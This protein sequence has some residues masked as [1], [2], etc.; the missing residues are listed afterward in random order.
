M[1]IIRAETAEHI[2]GIRRL[3]REYERFLGVDLCFQAF[4]EELA[5]LPGKYAPPDGAL[6]VAM[7]G[8]E[9]AGCVALRRLEQGVCEMKRLFVKEQYRGKGIG[10]ALAKGI[11]EEA[12][13]LGYSL[14]RLDTLDWLKE[15]MRLYES[16]GFRKTEPY[17]TNPLP[18]VVY[19]EL[20]I[21]P[22]LKS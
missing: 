1:K 8:Q 12:A 11:I 18:G 14:M 5:G 10:R 13:R 4:E 6:L 2:E 22:I 21:N 17:Y 3:F 20:E 9:L 7:E 16:L 15:A 19:W